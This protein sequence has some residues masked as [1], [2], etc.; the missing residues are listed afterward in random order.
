M[1]N[2]SDYYENTTDTKM[3]YLSVQQEVT[4]FDMSSNVNF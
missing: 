1:Y 4:R 3:A 2:I